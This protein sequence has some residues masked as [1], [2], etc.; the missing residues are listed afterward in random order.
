ML[1]ARQERHFTQSLFGRFDVDALNRI[2]AG[3]AELE[4]RAAT[5]VSREHAGA[6][7]SFQRGLDLRY[8]GQGF[9]L[10]IE[11]D[12]NTMGVG[13]LERVTEA[14]TIEHERTYG[15]SAPGEP[16]EIVNLRLVAH[17]ERKLTLTRAGHDRPDREGPTPIGRSISAQRKVRSWRRCSTARISGH[18]ACQVHSSFRS[19]TRRPSCP[20]KPTARLDEHG[21]IILTMATSNA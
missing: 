5:E 11:V 6:E 3:F 18:P 7:I 14:F 12:A 10:S 19:T 4:V 17:R 16:L 9:E 20:L 13:W 1:E 15:H 8:A 2:D 21:N